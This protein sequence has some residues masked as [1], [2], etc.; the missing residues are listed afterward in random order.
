MKA[1]I[2]ATAPTAYQIQSLKAFKMGCNDNGNGSFSASKEFDS[3][4]DAKNYLAD[5]AND[6]YDGDEPAIARNLGPNSLRLDAVSATI[7]E[8]ID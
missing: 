5:L 2:T 6:Y 1:I 3:V 7:E 8:L 4:E